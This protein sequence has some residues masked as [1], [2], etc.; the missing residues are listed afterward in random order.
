MRLYKDFVY[1]TRRELDASAAG[2]RQGGAPAGEGESALRRDVAAGGALGRPRRS[3]SSS[4][5][6]A[7]TW[8]I[9]SRSSSSG[10]SPI[11]RARRRCGRISCGCGSRVVAYVLVHELRRVALRGTALAPPQVSTIRTRLLKL[12]GVVR[13]SVR[14]IAVALSGVFPLHRVFRQALLQLQHGYPMRC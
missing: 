1:R 14:R 3:T 12:G 13:V 10:C 5:V 9:G 11:A 2:R 6:R 7:A 8:R 4:T